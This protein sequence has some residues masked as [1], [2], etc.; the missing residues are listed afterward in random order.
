MHD[1][2]SV[3]RVDPQGLSR[4]KPRS[5]IGTGEGTGGSSTH[6]LSDPPFAYFVRDTVTAPNVSLLKHCEEICVHDVL[7]MG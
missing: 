4:N 3:Q 6:E 2:H 1:A 5:T 7:E